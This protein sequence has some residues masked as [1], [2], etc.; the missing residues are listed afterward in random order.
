MACNHLGPI[1]IMQMAEERLRENGVPEDEWSGIVFGWGEDVTGS[2][3]T[4]VYT[5]IERR[6]DSWVVTKIDRRS[7]TIG[8]DAGLQRRES[9]A[10]QS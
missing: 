7:E 10:A 1:E 8:G 9:A 5:E 4:S 6:G 3:W 2:Q